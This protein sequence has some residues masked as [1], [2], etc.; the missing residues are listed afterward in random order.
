MEQYL[1]EQYSNCCG[2]DVHDTG[3]TDDYIC[4]ECYEHCE[5]EDA[6]DD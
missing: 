3:V 5:L 2:A 1:N 4:A 6:E